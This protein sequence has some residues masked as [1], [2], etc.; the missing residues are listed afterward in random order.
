MYSNGEEEKVQ[1]IR[2]GNS[3]LVKLVHRLVVKNVT[4]DCSADDVNAVNSTV[5]CIGNVPS[6]DSV[7]IMLPHVQ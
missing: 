7:A 6:I 3:L 1:R 5:P 2:A 4:Y